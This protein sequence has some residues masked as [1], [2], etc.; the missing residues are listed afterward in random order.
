MKFSRRTITVHFALNTHHSC[1]TGGVAAVFDSR[2]KLTNVTGRED[3]RLACRWKVGYHIVQRTHG[4][5]GDEVRQCCDQTTALIVVCK[6]ESLASVLRV[7]QLFLPWSSN[8]LRKP[9]ENTHV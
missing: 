2:I 8:G 5:F 3:V 9:C 7:S 1:E 4:D 6:E